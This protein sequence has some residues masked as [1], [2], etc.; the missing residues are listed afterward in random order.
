MVAETK[1]DVLYIRASQDKFITK[2]AV[3]QLEKQVIATGNKFERHE[4][5]AE[6]AFANPSNPQFKAKEAVAAE[7]YVLAFLKK[8]LNLE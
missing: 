6:H 1:K 3:D 2:D 4:C 5:V 8:R 7:Q